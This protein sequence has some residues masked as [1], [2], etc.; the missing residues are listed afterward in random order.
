[1]KVRLT[2]RKERSY[3]K[4]GRDVIYPFYLP[5]FNFLISIWGLFSLSEMS[6]RMHGCG[7]NTDV[8]I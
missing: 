2:Q 4:K 3:K 6:G 8:L 5:T 1:M 7:I